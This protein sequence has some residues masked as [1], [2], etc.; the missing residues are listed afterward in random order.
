MTFLKPTAGLSQSGGGEATAPTD[1]NWRQLVRRLDPA[2][3]PLAG[4]LK[5][6]RPY[7]ATAG[8]DKIEKD[9]RDTLALLTGEQIRMA[10]CGHFSC[11]KSSLINALV[12]RRLLPTGDFPE[13]GVPC[14]ISN[15][16]ANRIQAI[17]KSGRVGL[18][19]TTEAVARYVSL[20]TDSGEYADSVHNVE[21]LIVSLTGGGPPAGVV[22]VDSPGIN[23]TTAMTTRAGA[24]AAA[25]DVVIW[26]VN[27]RQPLSEGEQ[28]FLR[29]YTTTH[30]PASVVF[31]IN[32]FLRADDPANWSWFLAER[33]GYVRQRIIDAGITEPLSPV[34]VPISA[35]AAAL[36]AVD[37]FGAPEV[38]A[39]LG[40]L[41]DSTH[42]R[43]RATRCH[44]AADK[45][46]QLAE[47]IRARAENERARIEKEQR[48]RNELELSGP[49][50]RAQFTRLVEQALAQR[51]ASCAAIIEQR[52]QQI[53]TMIN[54]QALNRDN[55]YGQALA[56]ALTEIG[57]QLAHDITSDVNQYA[58]A[59]GLQAMT[60]A[61]VSTLQ[62]LLRPPPIVVTIPHTPAESGK[63]G[64]GAVIGGILGTIV[65]FH[66]GIG[67]VIGA[68]IGAAIGDK[69]RG[70]TGTQ[71]TIGKDRADTAANLIAASHTA[72]AHLGSLRAD[73]VRLVTS[74]TATPLTL[75][76]PP[77]RTA[78]DALEALHNHIAG[79]LLKLAQQAGA[80][81][82]QAVVS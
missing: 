7:L 75:P 25:A 22:W 28:A 12:G 44:R 39:L 51:F 26:V 9:L 68:G 23:D 19:F 72:A 33:L 63:G 67:T 70:E 80:Q 74:D 20:I 46:N 71:S 6:A 13:T 8:V 2:G 55:T 66:P 17:T 61:T 60:Q 65:T 49:A 64:V 78:L 3:E 73:V 81:A 40:S 11:G 27:S 41:T 16:S 59:S 50:R 31:V 1:R 69:I 30:G 47:T 35:R 15:G 43:I 53:Q 18:P 4:R 37:G 48:A 5:N 29:D 24:A 32:A 36:A 21:Y 54:T 34:M 82:R 14:V 79:T 57:Q 38:R 62:T 10:F 76:G 42:P 58:A 56:T 45:L 77:D 52:T